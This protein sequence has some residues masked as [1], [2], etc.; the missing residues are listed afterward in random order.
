[1]KF[2]EMFEG[3][4]STPLLWNDDLVYGL[5][6]FLPKRTLLSAIPKGDYKRLRLGKWVE[7]FVSLQL[8]QQSLINIIY[9]NLQIKND[10]VTIG[11]LDLL[12]TKDLQ[13]IHLEIVYKFYLYD[14]AQTNTT[15]LEHWIGPNR[16]DTLIQK[17]NKLKEKQLPLLYN[18]HTIKA[19]NE[20]EFNVATAEQY[21]CFKAQL[22]IPY[23]TK[24]LDIA[25]LNKACI[26]GFH[27]PFKDI[28]R[29]STYQIYIPS[30]LNWLNIPT[31]DVSWL[32]YDDAFKEIESFINT[33]K[34]PLI[35]VRLN[36][37]IQKLFI[38]W[39]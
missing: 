13:P 35:W 2:K 31:Q 11:E 7:A 20:T 14:S 30:K 3:F 5:K 9:E 19:I 34:S 8:R 12:F 32:N 21:V 29:L 37:K 10:K 23:K 16:N 4:E 24:D 36:T 26:S 33:K 15:K 22:F 27:M 6:Q 38:T 39:W 28:M 18:K 1:M 17:L 25:P